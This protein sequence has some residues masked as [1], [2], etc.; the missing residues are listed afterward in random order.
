MKIGM[1]NIKTTLSVFICLLIFSL[2]NRE[3]PI[4]ACI[5]AVICLQNTIDDS[6]KKGIERIIGTIIGGL[7]G[8]VLLFF[9]NKY[10]D[11]GLFIIIISLGIM[12]LIQVCVSINMRQ[13]VVICCVVYLSIMINKSHDGGYVLYTVN[14]VLDTSMG[15][16]VALL[17]NKY[18]RVPDKLKYIFIREDKNP[19][20]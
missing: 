4:Y 6:L 1:R 3:N 7:L 20:E 18:V 17:V 19:L 13:S 10:I 12:I 16:I 2:V 5:A 9:M 8:I 14:R 11:S 15:I